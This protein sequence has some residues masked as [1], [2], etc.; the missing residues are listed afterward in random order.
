MGL[1]EDA[2]TRLRRAIELN[3]NYPIAHFWLGAVLA[4]LGRIEE[5]GRSV[6]VGLT[7]DP[8]Y[9]IRNAR[10]GAMSDNAIYLKQRERI[11]EAMRKAGVPEG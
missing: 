11:Y 4:R 5:A 8:G 7:F 10:A 2:A 3:R 9:S 6:R 1:D